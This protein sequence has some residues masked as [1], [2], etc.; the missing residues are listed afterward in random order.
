[1]TLELA[2]LRA[3]RPEIDPS[4]AALAQR[5]ERVERLVRGTDAEP[6]DAEPQDNPRPTA[7]V[8]D[9]GPAAVATEAAD[10][11]RISGLWPAVL[12]QVRES[13]SELLST[14]FA[15]ARPVSV[16]VERAVLEIGFPA[17]ASF[18]KRK[19]EAQEARERLAE[20]VMTIVGE[21]LR[22]IY[23]L[24]DGEDA[25]LGG[26]EPPL[27]EEDLI[28]LLR[29]EFDAEEFEAADAKEAEG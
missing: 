12:D 20:A 22:P 15:A 25:T 21:R 28:A 27:G 29:S 17:S 7:V 5:L 11:E 26:A 24:L 4:R 14:V 10:L 13:G 19:A 8:T 23:V 9:P 1:M 3:A 18:N 6:T 16:D 2:M